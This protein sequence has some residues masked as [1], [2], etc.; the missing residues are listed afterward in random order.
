MSRSIATGA[1][2]FVPA[3]AV[4]EQLRADATTG[5]VTWGW[6]LQERSFGFVMFLLAF[7]AMAPGF[8]IGAGALLW[9]PGF[10]TIIGRFAPTFPRRITTRQYPMRRQAAIVQGPVPV[11]RRFRKVI[12]PCWHIAHHAVDRLVVI[13][14]VLLSAILIYVPI[15]LSNVVPGFVIAVRIVGTCDGGCCPSSAIRDSMP[16]PDI[17]TTG[18]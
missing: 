2:A 11:L 8:S 1:P 4:L 3:T 7:V 12:D 5:N 16:C 10:E 15:T 9:F 17:S 14:I 18:A 6:I 13:A